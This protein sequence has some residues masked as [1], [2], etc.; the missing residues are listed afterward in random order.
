MAQAQGLADLK[1]ITR[2]TS[3]SIAMIVVYIVLYVVV[4]ALAKYIIHG[5][6]P[7]YG[8]MVMDYEVY[9]QILPALAFGYLIVSAVA[10]F[11]YWSPSA[12]TAT[13][14]RRP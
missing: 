13:L 6:L 3:T 10:R 11:F 12:S 9:A 5:V 2:K 8:I 14:L 7:M 1:R 4:S